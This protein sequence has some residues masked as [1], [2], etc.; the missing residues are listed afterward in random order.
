MTIV[1][2]HSLIALGYKRLKEG[3]GIVLD[4]VWDLTAENKTEG[5]IDKFAPFYEAEVKNKKARSSGE[6]DDNVSLSLENKTNVFYPLFKTFGWNLFGIA[7]IKLVVT[8][9][10]FVAPA[11]LSSL[12]T[13]IGSNGEWGYGAR[14]KCT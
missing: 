7:F 1:D 13:F 10:P 6:V 5:I 8:W 11:V 14:S 12:I 4:E 9:L 3:F 2:S